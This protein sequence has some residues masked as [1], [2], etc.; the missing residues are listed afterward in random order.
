MATPKEVDRLF[1]ELPHSYRSIAARLRATIKSDAPNLEE[2]VKWNNPF[3]TGIK[4]VI[5]LQCFPDHVNLAFLRGAE[6]AAKFPNVEGTGKSMRHVKIPTEADA[7][8]PSVRELIRAA[9]ELD[10]RG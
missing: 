7:T 9:N 2:T 6:L 4:D 3:W 10:R 5:C 1:R 8:S